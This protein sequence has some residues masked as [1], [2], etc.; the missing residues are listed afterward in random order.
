MTKSEINVLKIKSVKGKSK[1]IVF[2][3]NTPEKNLY[4][5]CNFSQNVQLML[6]FNN[7]P[8]LWEI[9]VNFPLRIK[10]PL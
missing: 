2:S 5:A 10:S 3:L 1:E 4:I 6:Y 9:T 7:I 8:Y